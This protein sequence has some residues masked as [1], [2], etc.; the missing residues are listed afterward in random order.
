MMWSCTLAILFASA[1]RGLAHSQIE[2][3]IGETTSQHGLLQDDECQNAEGSSESSVCALQA[4]QLQRNTSNESSETLEA[5]Y[6]WVKTLY[7]QTNPN[8][9]K[10]ILKNGFRLGHVGWCGAG[11][12]F[13]TSVAAT[14]GKIKGPDSGAGYII[15]AKVN[16]G[17][18][19][20]MAWHCTSSAGCNHHPY[21]K[22]QDRKD[23][24]SWLKSQGY[25]SI[26]FTPDPYGPEYVIYDPDRVDKTGDGQ[27]DKD[28]F[29]NFMQSIGGVPEAASGDLH[30]FI[31]SD[32]SG[33]ISF[34]EFLNW[35][36]P[37]RELEMLEKTHGDWKSDLVSLNG[38]QRPEKPLMETR[39]GKPVVI[40]L[41][42]G[43]DYKFMA[44]RMKLMMCQ[45]F[46]PEQ[47]HWEIKQDG[48]LLATAFEPVLHKC[49]PDVE[50]AANLH[51]L[52]QRRTKS[53]TALQKCFLWVVSVSGRRVVYN[54]VH[55]LRQ[56]K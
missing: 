48:R 28:E 2:S 16:L 34:D 3:E 52:K 14:S 25:D 1:S 30:E 13:A 38:Y 50:R 27:L 41:W 4:L 22:C 33:E 24:G 5:S 12:Y 43:P 47:V 18:V 31:D 10:S 39:P 6:G 45:L 40:E 36:H 23:R 19:K 15:E 51:R 49:L 26:N 11:I 55:V 56:I 9:G 53:S 17:R 42:I 21:A 7:H 44:D 37:D 29:W 8:A 46:S 20:H 35:V 54:V 32:G